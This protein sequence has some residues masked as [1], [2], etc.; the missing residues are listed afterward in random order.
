MPLGGLAV[1]ET[2]DPFM[3]FGSNVSFLRARGKSQIDSSG[4]VVFLCV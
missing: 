3:T 4:K 2:G 1:L